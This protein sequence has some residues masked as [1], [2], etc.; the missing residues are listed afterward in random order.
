T[1]GPT[2]AGSGA[3]GGPGLARVASGRAPQQVQAIL[4]LASLEHGR[5]RGCASA[6]EAGSSLVSR[7]E[8]VGRSGPVHEQDQAIG[9]EAGKDAAAEQRHALL[10]EVVEHLGE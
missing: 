6:Q 4:R 7:A 3:A 10:S 8:R 5:E 9:I 2:G 1:P